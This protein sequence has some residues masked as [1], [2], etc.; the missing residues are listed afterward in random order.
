MVEAEKV[1]SRDRWKRGEKFYKTKELLF[2]KNVNKF[3]TEIQNLEIFYE[4]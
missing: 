1:L 2:H 3:F 4:F